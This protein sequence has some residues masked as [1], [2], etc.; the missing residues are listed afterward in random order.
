LKKFLYKVSF[1]IFFI[2]PLAS[3]SSYQTKANESF[4]KKYGEEIAKIKAERV[5]PR[6]EGDD[7]IVTVYTAPTAADIQYEA[8]KTDSEYYAY[9]DVNKFGQKTPQNYM[10]NREVYENA[11][12]SGPSYGIPPDIFEITYNTNLYPGFRKIGV[13]F[14]YINVPPYDAHG[15]RTAMSDKTYLLGG[16]DALQRSI[17]TVRND[18]SGDDVEIS[19]ILITEQRQLKKKQQME[20]IFGKD[21]YLELAVLKD[22]EGDE[23]SENSDKTST[24]N[25]PRP[26]NAVASGFVTRT[27][28]N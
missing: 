3:C 17:D 11:K 14:D 12:D 13:E 27:I 21:A 19:E 4:Q 5:H 2:S 18:R 9:V 26:V 16:G 20:K 28:R 25:Q 1:L 22:I 23:E 7:K 8:I 24:K 6:K 15:V 10:P